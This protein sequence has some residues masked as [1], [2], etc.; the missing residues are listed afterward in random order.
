MEK[1]MI[2]SQD[3]AVP[4]THL[5]TSAPPV[6]PALVPITF[7]LPVSLGAHAV[8]LVGEFTD[9]QPMPMVRS[10][11]HFLVS[12]NLEPGRSYRFK[13]LVD[14]V[15]WE[16]DW[17]ADDYVSNEFGGTDSVVHVELGP[18]M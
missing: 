11:E 16:N 6:G 2:D 13:Y 10:G 12:V 1:I 8:D 4:A 17:S 5:T 15:R 9:W 14:G 18:S 3:S 7:R